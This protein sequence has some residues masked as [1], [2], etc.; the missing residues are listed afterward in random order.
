M[1]DAFRAAAPAAL[2][3][4]LAL[5][6]VSAP[7][8]AQQSVTAQQLV[9]TWSLVSNVATAADGTKSHPFGEKPAGMMVFDSGGRYS[10]QVCRPGRPKFASDNRQKGTPG[11]YEAS[12]HGCN[13]HWGR[14]SV[15]DSAI[16]FSIE[17]AMFPNWEGV[18]Q[19]RPAT[20]VGDELKYVVPVGSTGGTNEVVW[21]RAR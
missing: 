14:Y 2:A 9:G 13:P 1:N 10:I 6:L 18:Q 4:A 15:A 21:R 16:T 8:R 12:V 19:K 5:A 17:H 7:A 3:T 20:L 11:E